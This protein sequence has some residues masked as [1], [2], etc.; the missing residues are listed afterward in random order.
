MTGTI[1]NFPLLTEKDFAKAVN[2]APITIRKRRAEGQLPYYRF[3]RSIRYS[4]EM[5]ED[6]K[7]KNK[8]GAAVN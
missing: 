2:L 3:G 1:S 5:V 6:F 8:H 4:W 7:Q